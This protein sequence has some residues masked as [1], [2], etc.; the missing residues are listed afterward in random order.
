MMCAFL[1]E[2]FHAVIDT[3]STEET[4][5]GYASYQ[6]YLEARKARRAKGKG[7]AVRDAPQPLVSESANGL[8]QG[9][10][11]YYSSLRKDEDGDEAH[12]FFEEKDGQLI[13]RDVIGI[14][15]IP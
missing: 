9:L 7:F 12:G 8:V 5:G 4:V 6:E 13:Q 3:Q 10:G 2:S 15:T 1:I 14:N 11:W